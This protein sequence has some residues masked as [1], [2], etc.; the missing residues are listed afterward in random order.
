MYLNS[1]SISALS[2]YI[3]KHSEHI[4]KKIQMELEGY[5]SGEDEYHADDLEPSR[6]FIKN[7]IIDDCGMKD[8]DFSKLLEAIGLQNR[9]KSIN[10][11]NNE[12]GPHS[13]KALQEILW[14]QK[15]EVLQ[16]YQKF[17]PLEV[18]KFANLKCT[19][20]VTQE[21]LQTID[22]T[23]TIR[24]LKKLKLSDFNFNE[25]NSMYYLN[26]LFASNPGL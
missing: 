18:L 9:L 19:L 10:Y 24:P 21:L 23:S 16:S 7:L 8:L 14:K 5:P 20:L 1:E 12:F 11:I 13:L 4:E 15:P 26:S 25:T 3:R 22:E 2:N 6:V 17:E